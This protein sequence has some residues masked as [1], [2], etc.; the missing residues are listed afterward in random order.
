MV[1]GREVDDRTLVN[2]EAVSTHNALCRLGYDN[3]HGVVDVRATRLVRDNHLCGELVGVVELDI[4]G[5]HV[6]L[7][8]EIS[9]DIVSKRADIRLTRAEPL[10]LEV[11]V[12]S[13]MDLVIGRTAFGVLD[14][15]GSVQPSIYQERSERHSNN[16]SKN[17]YLRKHPSF[18]VALI[19]LSSYSFGFRHLLLPS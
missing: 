19:I 10:L 1:V 8:V 18:S 15:I 4:R 17:D 14:I 7:V 5:I 3:I 12:F 16:D 6:Q 2:I 9:S 13:V 11:G